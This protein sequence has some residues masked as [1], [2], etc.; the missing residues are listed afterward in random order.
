MEG[1]QGA[2]EDRIYARW[3]K[4]LKHYTPEYKN[5]SGDSQEQRTNYCVPLYY[6]LLCPFTFLLSAMRQKAINPKAKYFTNDSG[7]LRATDYPQAE[8]G[9]SATGRNMVDTWDQWGDL[10]LLNTKQLSLK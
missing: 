7:K 2:T 10:H 3:N 5:Y 1:V 8:Y 4:Q 9:H 6:F